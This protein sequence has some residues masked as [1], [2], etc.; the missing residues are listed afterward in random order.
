MEELELAQLA[1]DEI[2]E[3]QRRKIQ[4][5]F[6]LF[7]KAVKAKLV[8]P[9]S[10]RLPQQFKEELFSRLTMLIDELGDL[11]FKVEA[12]RVLY[13]SVEV[14]RA[15]SKSDNFAHAFFR[16]GII[17]FTFKNGILAR[18]M[19]SFIDIIS[20]MLR[21]AAVDDDLA[22]LLWESGFEHIS[23]KLMDD[24][25]NIETFEY[26]SE[27]IRPKASP[28]STD[29][30]NLYENEINLEITAEDFEV[31]SEEKKKQRA[32]AYS[33]AA[34]SVSDY[35]KRVMMFSDEEKAEITEQVTQNA[36]LD[37]KAYAINVLFEILGL[38]TD[39]AGYHESLELFGKVRDD[40]IKMGDYA[41]AAMLLSRVKE[42]EQAFKNLKDLKL[43]KIQGFIEG[44]ASSDKIKVIVESLN[45]Q[46]DIDYDKVEEY[47]KM[48][49][50]QAITPLVIALG[51]LAHF[52]SRKAVCRALAHLSGDKVELLARGVDDPRW[53]VVRNV[54]SILGKVNNPKAMGYL[55]RTIRHPDIRVRKETLISAAKVGTEDAHDF[56]IMALNDEDEKIQIMALKELVQKKVGK[57]YNQIEKIVL[58][59][60]F[61]ERSSDQIKEFLEA[62]AQLGGER[63]YEP[64]NKMATQFTLLASEKQKR[65]K[66]YAVRALGYVQSQSATKQLEKISKSRDHALADTARR[67]LYRKLKGE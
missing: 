46:K 39:N 54:V 37:F 55:K 47:L 10:S 36:N 50:W 66:N 17:N 9:A 48:L 41:T 4:E 43:D 22:T 15:P 63:A 45:T 67:A 11:P 60:D 1:S 27:A 5:V 57:A 26:G 58:D 13:S 14:Y 51:E 21:S 8:Y 65:L 33:A 59:K 20:R 35:L 53:Y 56:L 32:N 19:E 28:S 64:L 42:M 40:Y 30:R 23:Y 18:E 31:P 24:V 62:M 3:Q 34:G 49:P 29:F 6:N 2:P 16:D 44:F 7:V 52:P 38:E 61:K 25:L 12:D